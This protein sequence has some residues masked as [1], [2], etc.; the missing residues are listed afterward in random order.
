VQFL[1]DNQGSGYWYLYLASDGTSYVV[2]SYGGDDDFYG[3]QCFSP[4]GFLHDSFWAAPSFEHFLYRHWIEMV[5][6]YQL[7]LLRTLREDL[8]PEARLAL[9]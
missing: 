3:V 6:Y 5:A 8:L 9:W 7:E 2:A 1:F 4:A